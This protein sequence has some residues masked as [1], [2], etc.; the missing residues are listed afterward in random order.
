[1][2]APGV[3][4]SNYKA[5][6]IQQRKGGNMKMDKVANSGNDEFYTPKYAVVPIIKYLKEKG[7]NRIWCPF[8]NA[9]SWF[10]KILS[11]CFDV[12]FSHISN[13]Q[14]FFDVAMPPKCDCIV[15]NPPYSVKGEVLQRLFDMQMPFAMLVGVVGL[16]ESEKRFTMFED[17]AF[18]I[19]YLNRPVSY[20]KSMTEQ[21]PS[22]NPPFSSVYLCSGV[23]PK[24]I[25]FE[26][27][28]K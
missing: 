2:F 25:C 17:N 10:V 5:G 11:E 9:D 12:T 26:R 13:G 4:T 8:D 14:N 23:L 28:Q 15:S 18:E 3:V 24:Q 19:L 6:A 22:L 7:F 27:I 16:F 1:M 20:F 21:K